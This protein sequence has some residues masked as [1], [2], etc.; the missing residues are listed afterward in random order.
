MAVGLQAGA[1]F[2]QATATTNTSE[3][4]KE[5]R[6]GRRPIRNCFLIG[7]EHGGDGQ[8]KKR[9]NRSVHLKPFICVVFLGDGSARGGNAEVCP[10]LNAAGQ[11]HFPCFFS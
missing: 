6:R 3:K 5:G 8:K 2:P 1:P 4:Q 10:A 11:M 9:I 7:F